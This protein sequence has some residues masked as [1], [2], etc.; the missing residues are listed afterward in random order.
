[1]SRGGACSWN[2]LAATRAV[3][4]CDVYMWALPRLRPVEGGGE[5]GAGGACVVTGTDWRGGMTP[6]FT[7]TNLSSAA[8]V[9]SMRAMRLAALSTIPSPSALSSRG[10]VRQPDVRARV[11]RLAPGARVKGVTP[12]PSSSVG[13][14][15]SPAAMGDGAARGGV[16]SQLP[17]E[18]SALGR[19]GLAL[20]LT[21]R[22]RDRV[23]PQALLR[24]R[25]GVKETR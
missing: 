7:A 12:G 21:L 9:S 22:V 14:E 24:R 6:L 2:R 13:E 5:G 23:E 11:L 8:A 19:P 17:H 1:M 25:A 10:G 3:G 16:V 20:A 4:G 18:W 15:P